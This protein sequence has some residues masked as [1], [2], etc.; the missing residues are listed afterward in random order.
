MLESRDSR[1]YCG[2][3]SWHYPVNFDVIVV[4]KDMSK[5]RSVAQIFLCVRMVPQ[6]R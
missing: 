1:H 3:P 4:I 2:P 5:G 6:P